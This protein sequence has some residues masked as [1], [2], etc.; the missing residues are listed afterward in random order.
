MVSPNGTLERTFFS[1]G[2]RQEAFDEYV[3]D[4]VQRRIDRMPEGTE[5]T[6]K[7]SGDI[8]TIVTP[9]YTYR[10]NARRRSLGGKAHLR[11]ADGVMAN[12][13]GDAGLASLRRLPLKSIARFAKRARGKMWYMHYQPQVVP[14]AYRSAALDLVRKATNVR[15]QQR[16]GEDDGKYLDRRLVSETQLNLLKSLAFDI[17]SVTAFAEWPK[18]VEQPFRANLRLVASKGANLS[19][20]LAQLRSTRR[21]SLESGGLAQLQASLTIPKELIPAAQS[22]VRQLLGPTEG[23]QKA[24]Q[25]RNILVASRLTKESDGLNLFAASPTEL[26]RHDHRAIATARGYSTKGVLGTYLSERTNTSIRYRLSSRDAGLTFSATTRDELPAAEQLPK[27]AVERKNSAILSFD[28]DLGSLVANK[29]STWCKGL[30]RDLETAYTRMRW[31]QDDFSR[32]Q[33]RPV[34]DVDSLLEFSKPGGDWSLSARATSTRNAISVNV[35][36]GS[37]LHAFWRARQQIK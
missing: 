27:L 21:A 18:Q 22:A 16:D 35:E 13:R 1:A 37:N 29:D 31:P 3:Q 26:T 12:S 33:N 20:M 14:A 32:S 11:Y 28:L 15:L 4:A 5:P 17:E 9:P 10:D 23:I 30:L 8:R 25:D 36:V 2:I 34:Q 7:V 24:I 6:L 19:R